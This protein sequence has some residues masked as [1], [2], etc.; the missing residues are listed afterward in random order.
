M[1]HA[2]NDEMLTV[3]NWEDW[4]E[5]KL[6]PIVAGIRQCK[7]YKEIYLVVGNEA[8]APWHVERFGAKLA[9][10]LREVHTALERTRLADR[11]KL[12]TPL[13]MSVP[14]ASYPPSAGQFSSKHKKVI[15]DVVRLLVMIGSPFCMN[16]YPYFAR[17][18]A[19]RDFVLFGPDAG[20]S[21]GDKRYTN[22]FS[23]QYD[24][25]VS[26]LSKLGVEGAEAMEVVVTE[27]GWPSGERGEGVV[28]VWLLDRREYRGTPCLNE[29]YSMTLSFLLEATVELT[30]HSRL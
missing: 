3:R 28:V 5:S 22:M 19:S 25:T 24:A 8:L 11:V 15:E 14:G 20:Y 27:T 10:C 13:E 6:Q 4:I 12:V 1:V 17:E 29:D 18:H 7:V 26:A 30:L 16:V 2:N 9:P 21:D 23:A